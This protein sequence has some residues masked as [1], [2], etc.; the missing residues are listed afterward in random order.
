MGCLSSPKRTRRTCTS[1]VVTRP[2]VPPRSLPAQSVVD[3]MRQEQRLGY[4]GFPGQTDRLAVNGVLDS[5]TGHAIG[6]FCGVLSGVFEPR[7]E[8]TEQGALWINAPNAPRYGDADPPELPEPLLDRTVVQ[9]G[10]DHL[11]DSLDRLFGQH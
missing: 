6:T 2:T 9:Q 4:L 5:D 3:V 1:S 8:F 7:D 11:T 10:I